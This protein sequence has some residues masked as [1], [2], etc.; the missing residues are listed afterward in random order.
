LQKFKR[1]LPILEEVISESWSKEDK[2]NEL[3]TELAAIDRKIHLSITPK[4]KE[5][6]EQQVERQKE[7]SKFSESNVCMPVPQS[8]RTPK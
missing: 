7:A 6:P 4:T 2:L 3:K 5:E 8:K 1:I